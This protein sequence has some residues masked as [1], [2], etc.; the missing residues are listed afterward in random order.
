[1]SSPVRVRF[2]PSP[3]GSLHIGSARTAL[4]NW[5]YARHHGGT[6][7]LRIEDTD[8]ERSTEESYRAIV[9]GLRWL[10]IDWDEGPLAG[11]A[12][13]PYFQSERAPLYDAAVDTLLA[14][15]QA[16]PCYCSREELE[17]R[18]QEAM[19]A[20]RPPKYNRACAALT[21]AE[22][23]AR[24]SA[25]AKP[26]VRVRI[27]DGAT[28]AWTDI[29]HGEISFTHD[30][31]DDF[32]IR[33]ADGHAIYN[34]AVVVDDVGMEITHVLRGDDHIS[35]TPKQIVLY[36]ALGL[37]PPLF[38]HMPLILGADRQK[39][40]KRH[41]PVGVE[42][43]RD[44]GFLPEALFN[45]IAL[46]GWSFDGEHE[47]FSQAQLREIF[48]P[49][50][51]SDT[52]AV[53][54]RTKLEWMNG[55]YM[56]RLPVAERARRVRPALEAAGMA[57][58]EDAAGWA[59]LER[60]VEVVG[61]RLKLSPDI[62]RYADYAF[63]ETVTYDPQA[64]AKTLA[65]DEARAGLAELLPVLEG[66]PDFTAE[67]LEALARE[68]I[69]AQGRKLGDVLQPAR[70]ALTGRTVSPGLFEVMELLGR[71]RVLAR[72]RAALPATAPAPA[73]PPADA[74]APPVTP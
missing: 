68:A 34:L 48:D 40:S 21:A 44:E 11:G 69:T 31:L 18:R 55:E 39:L 6:L 23:A 24:E 52:P 3:T 51:M 61:D 57:P 64:F 1:M 45:F 63:G 54:D 20:K 50:R 42:L 16:Y 12:F 73:A 43:F 56:R 14:G 59:Y 35:N 17:A 47:I 27:P 13:G 62:L 65:K 49:A 67:A 36:R 5:L 74:P 25:G 66:A 38:G 37:E 22:R 60:V 4:F 9:D 41:G 30:N 10:N 32:I 53:F 72:L 29:V 26:A 19:K 71:D 15:D 70:V 8:A 2:A 46:L 33:R 58:A 28:T 7:V